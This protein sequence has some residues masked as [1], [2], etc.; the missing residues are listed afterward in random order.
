[1]YLRCYDDFFLLVL[2]WT[3][4]YSRLLSTFK[5]IWAIYFY[6]SMPSIFFNRAGAVILV[7]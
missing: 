7:V 2:R 1:M 4:P 6:L 3:P 5:F